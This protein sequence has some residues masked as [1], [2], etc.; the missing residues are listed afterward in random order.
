M[1]ATVEPR[2][3][4]SNMQIK[5]LGEFGTLEI[6][7]QLISSSRPADSHSSQHLLID[8]GDDS[9]G[10]SPYGS[11]E[12]IT[13]D[14]VVEGI[15]FTSETISWHNLGWKALA[16]NISDIA[17]MG[18]LPSYAVVTLGLPPETDIQNLTDL[19]TGMLSI[20]NQYHIS[21]IGGDMVRSNQIFISITLTGTTTSDPLLRTTANVGDIV[22][23]TGYLGSSAGGLKVI[24][25]SITASDAAQNYLLTAPQ[26]PTPQVQ[27]GRTLVDCHIKTAMDISDGLAD[28]LSKL[29]LASKVSAEIFLDRIPTHS[30]LKSSFPET[31]IE[32]ALFGGEDYEL[33]FTG[34]TTAVNEAIRKLPEGASI[35]GQITDNNPGEVSLVEENGSERVASRQGWDHFT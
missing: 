24:Q 27:S 23:V 32:L 20:A 8:S 16:S 13:T 33:L 19:Y 1:S 21:I 4:L 3:N 29:C 28:D 22:A 31:Y 11:A 14:T 25:Q 30:I 26:T 6:I 9:A 2:Y 7:N 5:D 18:A 10:W 34:T 12:L 17:S 35:I 15:H